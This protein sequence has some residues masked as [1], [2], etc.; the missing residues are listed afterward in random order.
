[1]KEIFILNKKHL[2]VIVL[3]FLTVM[4]PLQAV[5]AYPSSNVTAHQSEPITHENWWYQTLS[6]YEVLLTPISNAL[7]CGTAAGLPGAAAGFFLGTLDEG[8]Y[9]L[10]I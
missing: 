1:M 2:Q 8:A 7:V 6:D 10:W 3:C 9:L 4:S 5:Q